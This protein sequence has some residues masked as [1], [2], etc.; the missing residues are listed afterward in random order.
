MRQLRLQLCLAIAVLTQIGQVAAQDYPSRPITIVVTFPAG[1]PTDGVARTLAADMSERL[2]RRV[3]IENKGGAAGTIGAAGVAKSPP[4]GYVLLFTASGPLS[5][6]RTL[7]RSLSYDPV[8]DLAPVAL[9]GTIPQVLI[10]S[11]KLPASNLGELI[12]HAKANPGKLNIGDSGIGTTLHILAVLLAREA[13]IE[14]AHVHYR[15]AAHSVTD[16]MSGQIEAALSAFLP[17]F[18]TM[19]A[20]GVTWSRRLEQLPD[21]PTFR[22]SGI[23]IVSGLSLSMAAPAGTPAAIVAKLNAAV[24]AYLVSGRGR[25]VAGALGLQIAGGTPEELRAFL[26]QE[27]ARL[28]PVIEAAKIT[29]AE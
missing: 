2:G 7:Y 1:G 27:S 25:E 16:V 10:A 28:E 22:E 13:G 21:V 17:Q 3:N 26:A 20:L 14:V 8:R 11:P 24:N 18:V 12:A 15:G 5:Y 6:Y 29:L 23:D 4:D 19:K 9:I